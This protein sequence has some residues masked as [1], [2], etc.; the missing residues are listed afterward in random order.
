MLHEP[1][2][3]VVSRVGEEPTRPEAPARV[4]PA[5]KVRRHVRGDEARDLARG[6]A[7]GAHVSEQGQTGLRPGPRRAVRAHP[8]A[9]GLLGPSTDLRVRQAIGTALHAPAAAVN[10][11]PHH[12]KREQRGKMAHPA[13]L[14][15]GVG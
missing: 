8:E 11:P 1:L 7:G 9:E 12:Q 6:I 4:L 13:L 2:E 15:S 10:D 3:V 5:D 14:T